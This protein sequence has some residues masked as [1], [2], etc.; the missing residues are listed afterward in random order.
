MLLGIV[1]PHRLLVSAENPDECQHSP[2]WKSEGYSVPMGLNN[3]GDSNEEGNT[4]LKPAASVGE[5]PKIDVD[6]R[7]SITPKDVLPNNLGGKVIVQ[8]C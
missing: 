6:L 4:V 1:H 2:G 8:F 3:I 7:E 5:N